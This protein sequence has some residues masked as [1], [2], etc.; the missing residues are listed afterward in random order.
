[1]GRCQT[2][3]PGADSHLGLAIWGASHSPSISSSLWRH[4]QTTSGFCKQDYEKLPQGFP[5][6]LQEYSAAYYKASFC[7]RFQ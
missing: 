3:H 6:I 1:M 5:K 4:K 2:P 7:F